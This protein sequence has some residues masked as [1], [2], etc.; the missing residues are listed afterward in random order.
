MKN[1]LDRIS[2][3]HQFIFKKVIAYKIY[4]YR[5]ITEGFYIVKLMRY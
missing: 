3:D 4:I 1:L 2:V 5:I